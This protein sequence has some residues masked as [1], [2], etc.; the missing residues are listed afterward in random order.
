[1]PWADIVRFRNPSVNERAMMRARTRMQEEGQLFKRPVY[2]NTCVY[3]LTASQVRLLLKFI[4]IGVRVLN[5]IIPVSF[6]PQNIICVS[7]IHP[8]AGSESEDPGGV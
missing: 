5:D 3:S 8:S 6:I 7:L 2:G 4:S 1:M